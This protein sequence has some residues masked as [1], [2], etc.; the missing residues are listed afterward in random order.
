MTVGTYIIDTWGDFPTADFNG[1]PWNSLTPDIGADEGVV[2]PG[3]ITSSTASTSDMEKI[4]RWS[5]ATE[6][7]NFG[8]KIL[9]KT[10]NDEFANVLFI[11]WQGTT[12][13]Q[14]HYCFANKNTNEG[15]YFYHLKQMDYGGQYSYSATVEVDV[16][17]LDKC[18]LEQN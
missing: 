11:C 9:G 7:N 1:E 12:T 14:N 4:L 8:F 16:R 13:Q 18:V 17:M 15:K 5:T 2:V 6:L 10:L 3:E